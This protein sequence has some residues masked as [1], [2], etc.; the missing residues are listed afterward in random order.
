MRWSELLLAALVGLLLA[1]AAASADDVDGQDIEIPGWDL[2]EDPVIRDMRAVDKIA[3]FEDQLVLGGGAGL[4]RA[5]EFV[6]QIGPA[7]R[8]L[9]EVSEEVRAQALAA[10]RETLGPFET[11]DGVRMDCA[12]WIV[13]ARRGPG[14]ATR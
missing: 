14:K 9:H 6:S 8:A 4:D 1:P 2:I 7:G 3:P 5:V 12:T 13:S 11:P 10:V